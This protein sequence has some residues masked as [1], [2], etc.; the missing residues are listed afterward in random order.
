[1]WTKAEASGGPVEH[2]KLEWS[3]VELKSGKRGETR[4]E[5]TGKQS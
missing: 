4:E 5:I 2:M 1:M 3:R